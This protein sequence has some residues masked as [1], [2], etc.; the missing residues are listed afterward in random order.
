M[1]A[2]ASFRPF[3]ASLAFT[4]VFTGALYAVWYTYEKARWLESSGPTK[5][6]EFA[7]VKHF[8]HSTASVLLAFLTFVPPVL[9][10]ML[11]LVCALKRELETFNALAG[12]CLNSAFGASLKRIIKQPRPLESA[13]SG[14]GMPSSHA[15]FMSFVLIYAS[16]WFTSP[17]VQRPYKALYVSSLIV[18]AFAVTYSRLHLR[19]HSIEQLCAGVLLG[20]LTGA[21][22]HVLSEAYT[23][24]LLF[25]KV[26]ESAFGRLFYLRDTGGIPNLHEFEYQQVMAFKRQQRGG[27]GVGTFPSIHIKDPVSAS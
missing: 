25:N 22:W 12:I 4:A 19:V 9:V 10:A 20:G 11:V 15:M 3:V 23:R 13:I 27:G 24:P 2:A 26:E 21:L 1:T 6:L 18:L 14:Y 8:D 16:L 7:L 17:R 5:V